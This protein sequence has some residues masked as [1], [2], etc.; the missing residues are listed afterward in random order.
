MMNLSVVKEVTFDCCHMLSAYDGACA[1]LHGH[2]YKLQIE[3]SGPQLEAPIAKAGMV[4]DFKDLKKIIKEQVMDK[5]DHALIIS[6]LPFR[7]H[8]E[9]DLLTWAQKYKMKRHICNG[10]S[11]AETMAQE[12]WLDV[13]KEIKNKYPEVDVTFVRLWETPT[14]FAE[15]RMEYAICK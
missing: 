13:Q 6:A 7:G 9:E 12:I 11:T 10:R 2:T 4:L 3:L 5:M 14:S 15:Y 1:D 8:A